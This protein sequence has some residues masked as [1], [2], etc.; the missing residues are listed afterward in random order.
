MLPHHV[1]LLAQA[2]RPSLVIA[3]AA[4]KPGK[5]EAPGAQ[6]DLAD[7]LHEVNS[8]D[9]SMATALGEIASLIERE[10]CPDADIYEAA[11]TIR[12]QLRL[13]ITAYR[14]ASALTAD[15]GAHEARC[16]LAR[17]ARDILVACTH[18]LAEI[19]AVTAQ[20]W[21]VI[22]NGAVRIGNN[23]FE[24]TLHCKTGLPT[25][26]SELASWIPAGVAYDQATVSRALRISVLATA[27][28]PLPYPTPTPCPAP[29]QAAGLSVWKILGIAGIFSL[30]TGCDHDE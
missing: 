7:A 25:N 19:I 18:F 22:G 29:P 17:I 30:L 11:D 23:Q 16:R 28:E 2:L 10:V 27:P 26:I 9:T 14:N 1:A 4:L 21:N 5:F 15:Y 24:L 6:A 20:P 13:L 3:D 12:A 8:I